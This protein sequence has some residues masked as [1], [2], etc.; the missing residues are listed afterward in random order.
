MRPRV[1]PLRLRTCRVC[2]R[3]FV[4]AS[5]RGR[6]RR[7][8]SDACRHR[9]NN[10]ATVAVMHEAGGAARR[11]CDPALVWCGACH[12]NMGGVAQAVTHAKITDVTSNA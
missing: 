7:Y 6:A 4:V 9:R 2:P 1:R 10:A 8:C 3:R 12:G 11:P 5:G